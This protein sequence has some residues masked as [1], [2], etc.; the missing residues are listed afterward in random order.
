MPF[1]SWVHYLKKKRQSKQKE[2]LCE[3]QIRKLMN[4]SLFFFALCFG[5]L[6]CSAS[7]MPVLCT[8]SKAYYDSLRSQRVVTGLVKGSSSSGSGSNKENSHCLLVRC[9]LLRWWWRCL[10]CST[11]W[12]D[13]R[14][15]AVGPAE[16]A[17]WSVSP[18]AA[19]SSSPRKK[20]FLRDRTI[21]TKQNRR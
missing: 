4:R 17:S 15:T 19:S 21:K 11:R 2:W 20:E 13:T 1:C 9:S 14:S 16:T 6:W 10:H 18:S 8:L 7:L 12:L 3:Q 5:Y